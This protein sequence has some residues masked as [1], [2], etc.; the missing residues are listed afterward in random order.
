M[1]YKY[2]TYNDLDKLRKNIRCDTFFYNNDYMKK[3]LKSRNMNRV[4]CDNDTNFFWFSG[5]N[6]II[7][8]RNGWVYKDMEGMIY[9]IH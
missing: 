1:I 3:Y 4:D 5:N 8:N 7:V 2:Y 6:Y 9:V